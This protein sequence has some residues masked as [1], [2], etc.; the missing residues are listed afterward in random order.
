[1]IPT[2]EIQQQLNEFDRLNEQ[3]SLTAEL[4]VV[5]AARAAELVIEHHATGEG[6]LRKA[7]QL[8]CEIAT[9]QDQQVARAGVT[10]LFPLLVERL[11]DSFDPVNC[12]LYDQL[13]IQVIEFCRCLP[14]GERLD[15]GL[16]QFGLMN[17]AD[18]LA[19]KAG[20]SNPKSQIPNP[21][22]FKL[23]KRVLLLSRVTI[24][25]DIAI[26]SAI[27]A[28]LRTALPNAEFVILGSGKLRELY[29]GD[30]RIRIREV[31]Y[32][33]GGSLISRLTSWL[34]VV[35]AVNEERGELDEDEF[36]VIDPDS[37]LTQLGL[38][39]LIKNDR[40]YYF[41]ES[42][43][44]QGDSESKSIG[45][46]AAHWAGEIIES[47]EPTYPFITLPEDHLNFGH[48]IANRLR[49]ETIRNPQSAIRNRIVAISFGV[50]G[51]HGKRVSDEFEEQL[52]HQLLA[53]SKLIL[54]KGASADE[55]EQINRIVAGIR[56]QGQIVIE[57]N[58][59]NKAAIA[60]QDWIEAD[61]VTWDGSIGAFAGL[62][63]ASDEYIGYDSAGQ[64]IAAALGVPVLTIF[65]NSNNNKFAERW[66]P[67]GNG[68]IEV[69]N[70]VAEELA[71]EPKL[72]NDVLSRVVALHQDNQWR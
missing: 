43:S 13:F 33:R 66:R 37:R 42:R 51:N 2:E 10:A 55:R 32:E 20:L 16:K 18:L 40:N 39:P 53:D 64:H 3:G 23:V 45:Q 1:M 28:K 17:E 70:V 47:H 44:D 71:K 6:Y 25:A 4:A 58:D 35:E 65:V 31:T 8:I 59:E 27:I 62:V 61:V 21:A 5:M 36:W 41:F 15:A 11:N 68:R 29:G 7:V 30:A 49:A 34:D 19:R 46:L 60:G 56:A 69:I 26:T 48:H 72:A 54:D 12:R 52:I 14:T 38:L 22:S 9:H 24:G 57:I 63:A 50:G 67:F